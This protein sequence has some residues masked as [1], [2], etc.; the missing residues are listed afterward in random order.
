MTVELQTQHWT[1]D[2]YWRQSTLLSFQS[3]CCL[4][5]WSHAAKA[6]PNNYFI[7]DTVTERHG[8]KG[9]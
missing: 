6:N 2:A 3:H 5:F 9:T 4:G 8:F 7:I 1:A